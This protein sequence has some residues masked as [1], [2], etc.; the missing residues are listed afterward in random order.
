MFEDVFNRPP[1]LEEPFAQTLSGKK[2]SLRDCLCD[3]V[4]AHELC[5]N[6]AAASFFSNPK[7]QFS[8]A[9]GLDCEE[10]MAAQDLPQQSFWS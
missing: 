1:L 2:P 10:L 8:E 5:Q 6:R 9:L 4:L 3:S 7:R